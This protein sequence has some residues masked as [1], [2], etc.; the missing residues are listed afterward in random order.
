MHTADREQPVVNIRRF[1]PDDAP[2]LFEA[3]QETLP[4]LCSFMAWCRA[5]YSLEDARSFIA[6]CAGTRDPL[7]EYNFAIIDGKDQSVLGS[8]GLNRIDWK[9]RCA[10]LGY[11][12]R[13]SRSRQGVATAA[14]QL[15]ARFALEE[16][17]LHRLEILI[18]GHNAA[19]QRVA[20]K[21]GAAF[22]GALRKRLVLADGIHDAFLYSLVAGNGAPAVKPINPASRK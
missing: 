5:D 11:W 7:D 18:A 16:L 20:Q 8:A 22:E 21:A 1:R 3:I 6:G 9:H 13:R 17:G 14:A 19:S 12:V 10:N 15:V 4:E 2:F